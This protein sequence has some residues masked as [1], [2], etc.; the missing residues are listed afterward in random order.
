MKTNKQ[1]IYLLEH[2]LEGTFRCVCVCVYFEV[3]T[4]TLKKCQWVGKITARLTFM[5]V[6][7]YSGEVFCK[8]NLTHFY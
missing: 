3:P 6:F 4:G 8:L 5:N 1:A 2:E 7:K